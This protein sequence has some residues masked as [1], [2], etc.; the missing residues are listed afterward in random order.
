MPCL[1]V[2]VGITTRRSALGDHVRDTVV[3]LWTI[4][5]DKALTVI[6]L[7]TGYNGAGS[8]SLTNFNGF[9]HNSV[10]INRRYGEMRKE[11]LK[12][13]CFCGPLYGSRTFNSRRRSSRLGG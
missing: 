5:I 8:V 3:A 9:C 10:C 12:C 2:R 4:R 11:I 7:F 1:E 6:I 13:L